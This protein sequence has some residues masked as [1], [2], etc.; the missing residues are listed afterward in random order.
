MAA[1]GAENSREIVITFEDLHAQGRP[2]GPL[3]SNYAGL[4]WS[5]SAWFMT[6]D[7][8]SSVCPKVRC[9]LLNAHGRD[10]TIESEHLFGLRALSLC[11][12]WRD[13]AQVLVEGWEKQVRKYAETLTAKQ[14]SVTL[15][16]LD[17]RAIDRVE[18]KAGGAHIVISTIT[19]LFQ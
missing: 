12:L 5:D 2:M 9:G 4:T 1:P 18:L 17:Y 16:N 11:T 13:K 6:K 19:V 8:L 7:F 14:T 3:P 10:I 15:F